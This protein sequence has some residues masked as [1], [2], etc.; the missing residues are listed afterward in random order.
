MISTAPAV[1]D[2]VFICFI[3]AINPTKMDYYTSAEE[4]NFNEII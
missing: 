4:S 2:S 3:V 1:S